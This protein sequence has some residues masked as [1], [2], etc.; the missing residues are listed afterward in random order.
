MTDNLTKKQRKHTMKQVRS[1]NTKPEWIVRRT[2][3]RL[4]FRYR[5]HRKDLPG[6]P[7]LVFPG[8]KK[9]IFVHG[10]FWHQHQG[11]PAS[12]RP[13]SN[14]EYWNRKLDRNMERDQKNI[15][16]LENDGWR[17]LVIWEC[18]IKDGEQLKTIIRDFFED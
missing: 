4:G 1:K 11:C 9:I 3:F 13:A 7:D 6:K 16:A 18:Q 10:C 8:R 15:E 14:T 5:L 17:V 2:V 12:N